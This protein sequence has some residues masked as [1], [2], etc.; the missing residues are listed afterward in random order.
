MGEALIWTIIVPMGLAMWGLALAL[1]I[2]LVAAVVD[3]IKSI[4]K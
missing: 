2:V 4:C 3:Y 1:I